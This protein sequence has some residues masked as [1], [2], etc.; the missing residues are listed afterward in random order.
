MENF[1]QFPLD[2]IKLRTTF[3]LP[4]EKQHS[5]LI[6][7]KALSVATTP[8]QKRTSQKIFFRKFGNVK[9]K[10]LSLRPV[11][12]KEK[13]NVLYKFSFERYKIE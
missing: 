7:Q 1:E 5:S 8:S 11:S 3:A 6:I 10:I 12:G 4:F 9:Q 2:N 13:Q